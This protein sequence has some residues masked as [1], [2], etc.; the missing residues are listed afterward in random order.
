MENGSYIE[1]SLTQIF[2]YLKTKV[3]FVN[4]LLAGSISQ[5][6]APTNQFVGALLVKHTN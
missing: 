2:L 6:K 3:F 5:K 1:I 4:I